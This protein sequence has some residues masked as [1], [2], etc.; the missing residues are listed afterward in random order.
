[1]NEIYP[2]LARILDRT[3]ALTILE[4]GAHN[5]ADSAQLKRLFPAAAIFSFEPDPRNIR[6]IRERGV[7]RAVTLVEAAVGDRD[8]TATFHLSSANT[9]KPCPAWIRGPEWS[10]SSS[11]KRPV[12][13]LEHHPWCEFQTSVEV[14]TTRLDTFCEQQRLGLIDLIWADVQGAE[15]LLIAGAAKTL[16]A[17]SF[18]Y[19]EYAETE[20]YQGQLGLPQIISRLPG[21]WELV[22][23]FPN[24]A[25]LRNLS[26]ATGAAP[27]TT[28]V[29]ASA[30]TP[31]NRPG[32]RLAALAGRTG[33]LAG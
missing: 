3:A 12:K 14:R 31:A 22:Q 5:G 18:F 15:D 2:I 21:R 29:S 19:T 7:D 23:K 24:D 26:K 13:H 17:T 10:G 16:A 8:G 27:A 4:C 11:L 6:T 1:M 25:L 28:A 9:A 30:G 33:L 20:Q 32:A